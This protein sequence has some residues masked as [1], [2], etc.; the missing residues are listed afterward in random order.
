MA[1]PKRKINA[2][3]FLAD[4]ESGMGAQE[5]KDTHGLSDRD[6]KRLL[7]TLVERKMLK[8]QD[9]RK[10]LS[11]R[12]PTGEEHTGTMDL[13]ATQK[14]T[15]KPHAPDRCPQCGAKVSERAL[16]CPECGHMLPGQKRWEDVGRKKGL[17]DRLP[18]WALGCIVALPLAI[19]AFYVL[20]DIIMPMT[21]ATV[22]KRLEE[23]KRR[24]AELATKTGLEKRRQA[25]RELEQY[26]GALV[27]TNVLTYVDTSSWI[28]TA[29]SRW[30]RMPRSETRS[31]L[32][33]IRDMM[34][35]AG[36]EEEIKVLDLWENTVAIVSP[37]AI[38]MGPFEKAAPSPP[39]AGMA[40]PQSSPE[41][42]KTPPT[43]TSPQKQPAGPAKESP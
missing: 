23:R 1:D 41:P 24:R 30:S 35:D 31:L 6:F 42:D 40:P 4:Y 25:R 37:D 33:E 36:Y 2:K 16:T 12:L 39:P 13:L 14:V 32:E 26:L 11:T 9:I 15:P 27:E 7:K 21:E 3:K 17:L 10:L 43:P 34:I 8:A 38:N 22:E 18:P 29:G 28:L 5:L 20:D 19:L